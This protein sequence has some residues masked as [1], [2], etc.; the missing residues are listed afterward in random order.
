MKIAVFTGLLG[1]GKTSIINFLAGKILREQKKR[2]G[3]VLND[4]GEEQLKDGLYKRCIPQESLSTLALSPAPKLFQNILLDVCRNENLDFLFVEPSG[5][6]RPWFVKKDSDIVETA[7]NA[8]FAH[9]PIINV[10]DPTRIDLLFK[11]MERLLGNGI[12]ESD[13]VAINKMDAASEEM[14]EKTEKIIWKLRP[15]APLF[16]VSAKT[17]KGLDEILRVVVEDETKRYENW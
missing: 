5:I 1:S 4:Q 6:A 7:L 15:D 12:V 11:A 10:V 16:Y 14:I 8:K 17:H 3:V 9:A 2:I 13:Y